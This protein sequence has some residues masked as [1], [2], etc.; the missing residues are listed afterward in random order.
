[1]KKI[2]DR[3]IDNVKEKKSH[4]IVGLDPNLELIPNYLKNKIEN[5]EDVGKVIFE[6]NKKIIDAVFDIVPVIKPQSAFY[7]EYGIPGIKAYYDTIKYGQEKGLLV[8]GDVKRGDIGSTAKAYSAGHIGKVV[9]KNK[10]Y[11]IFG[12]DAVTVNP[13]LGTD[14]I[15]PFL[16]DAKLYNKG[17]F[18]LVKNIQSLFG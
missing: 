12:A 9:V 14:N 17:L 11:E 2:I 8:I 6:F 13:Y 10:F 3:I 1:M 16:D 15:K 4:V 7:E 18:I 5:I